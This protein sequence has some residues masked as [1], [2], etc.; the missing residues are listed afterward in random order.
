MLFSY[1]FI[2]DDLVNARSLFLDLTIP[3][4]DPLKQAKLYV[5][6]VAPGVRIS[7]VDQTSAGWESEF[8]WVSCVNEED[9]FDFKVQRTVDGKRELKAFWK[10]DEIQDVKSLKARLESDQLWPVFL[11]RAV[12]IVTDRVE[13]QLENL[14]SSVSPDNHSD[15]VNARPRLVNLALKLKELEQALLENSLRCLYEQ[16]RR[17]L[18]LPQV[19]RI[20]YPGTINA[21]SFQIKVN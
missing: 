1:G 2:E 3:D 15:Q 18:I 8:V 20:G 5:S 10:D 19:Y 16:V 21:G 7:Q 6:D 13:A 14:L 9:G 11:L 4:D 12:C 17:L